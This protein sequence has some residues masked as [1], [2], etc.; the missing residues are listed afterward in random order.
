MVEWL[1]A[2]LLLLA[3][4]VLLSRRGFAHLL[5]PALPWGVM[6]GFAVAA[7]LLESLPFC[8]YRAEPSLLTAISVAVGLMSGRLAGRAMAGWGRGLQKDV[9]TGHATADARMVHPLLG[10]GLFV[11]GTPLLYTLAALRHESLE[12]QETERD[13][14]TSVVFGAEDRRMPG[15]A[16]VSHG[17]LLV[18]GFLGSPADLGYLPWRLRE[19]GLTVRALR[20]PGHGTGPSVLDDVSPQE[21]LDAVETAR[22]ELSA[23]CARVSVVGFSF[24]GAL[25]IRSAA[26]RRPWRLVLVNPWLGDTWTPPWMPVST[27]RMIDFAAVTT[28]RVIKPLGMTRCNDP[29]GVVRLRAYSTVRTRAAKAA[30]DLA[31]NCASP[32]FAAKLTSPTLVLLSPQDHTAKAAATETWFSALPLAEPAKRLL[33]FDRSDHILLQDFDRDAATDA[34][35]EFLTSER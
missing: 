30:R 19:R 24:G 16:A 14:S 34:I 25:A 11:M 21:Y 27:D 4:V 15:D 1:F 23:Q 29:D 22:R 9:A 7:W 6:A 3:F 33:C 32:E 18:H 20:L 2:T 28:P 13:P 26:D 8:Q 35:V 12:I 5:V 17:V 31:R 10:A